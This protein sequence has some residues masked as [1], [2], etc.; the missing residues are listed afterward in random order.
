MITGMMIEAPTTTANA[1]K[2]LVKTSG[3]PRRSW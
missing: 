3:S 1:R 2:G